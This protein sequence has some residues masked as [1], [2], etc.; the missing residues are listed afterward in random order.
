MQHLQQ[1]QKTSP[2]SPVDVINNNSFFFVYSDKLSKIIF[3]SSVS[4][5]EEVL[6]RPAAFCCETLSKWIARTTLH[7]P[8][9]IKRQKKGDDKDKDNNKHKDNDDNKKDSLSAFL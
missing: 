3:D 8:S 4:V 7:L 1:Q 5:I 9:K 2:Q 6:V